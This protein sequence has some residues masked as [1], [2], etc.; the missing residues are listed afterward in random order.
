MLRGI[1]AFSIALYHSFFILN[2][3]GISAVWEHSLFDPLPLTAKITQLISI[4]FNGNMWV[5]LFFVLSGFFL[6]GSLQSLGVRDILRYYTKRF[7]RLYPP[8]LASLLLICVGL[9]LWPQVDHT[10]VYS[11]W[12]PNYS[13]LSLK[14]AVLSNLLF[15]NTSLSGVTWALKVIVVATL[16]APVFIFVDSKKSRAIDGIFLSVLIA[17]GF[18]RFRFDVYPFLYLFYLGLIL[19]R[20]KDVFESIPLIVGR[21][22]PIL[23]VVMLG[24]SFIMEYNIAKLVQAFGWSFILGFYL[25]TSKKISIPTSP[26]FQKLGSISFSFYLLHFVTLFF[27]AR[28]FVE[29]IPTSTSNTLFFHTMVAA[30]SII[31]TYI[32]ALAVSV[33]I[34][35]PIREWSKKTLQYR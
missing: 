35:K 20:Y 16:L 3:D 34:E 6:R 13:S 9:I 33:Y 15:L 19:P 23:F 7:F 28:F 5:I 4:G 18:S 14:N 31:L 22:L 2:V 30:I 1:A 12:F 10:T 21:F 24:G 11:D 25:Y 17:Y 26:F 8:Y 29:Y 27:C 32:L